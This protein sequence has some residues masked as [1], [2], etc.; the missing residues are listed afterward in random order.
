[1]FVE[2]DYRDEASAAAAANA[3]QDLRTK[4]ITAG[5]IRPDQALQMAVDGGDAP[6]EFIST[7]VTPN[8][9]LGSDEKPDEGDAADTG[10]GDASG[11]APVDETADEMTAKE[12]TSEIRAAR[13][14]VEQAMKELKDER[15]E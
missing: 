1:M 6:K 8:L 10:A 9:A 7:D 2:K 5:M 12:L 14:T 15:T 4:M 11:D 3:R 13:L